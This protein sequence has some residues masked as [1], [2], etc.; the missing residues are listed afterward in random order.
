MQPSR[1]RCALLC[2]LVVPTLMSAQAVG[3]VGDDARVVPR[4]TLRVSILSE[5]TRYYER[6]GR[7]TPGRKDGALE[8][9][10]V[11]FTF[12][13]LGPLRLASL[14]P[15]EAGVRALSGMP[16]FN[17]SLGKIGVQ[18]RDR[19]VTTPLAIDVGLTQRLT[20]GVVIPFVT[21]TSEVDLRANPTGR[22]STLG[23]NPT[24]STPAAFSANA[25]LLAQFDSAAAQL[26]QRLSFCG[27]NPSVTGCGSLNANAASARDLIAKANGFATGLGQIYGGRNGSKGALFVPIS[28]TTAQAAIESRVAAYRALYATF[29]ATALTATGPFPAQVPLT[30]SDVQRVITDSAFGIRA[31][32]LAGSIAR[33]LGD[34]DVSVK[35]RVV[36]TFGK[37]VDERAAPKGFGWRQSVGAVYRLGTGTRSAPDNFTD[38]GTGDHQNDIEMR[39]FTDLSFGGRLW[40]AL[41]A[42]YNIQ[43]AD[44][45]VTRIPE[46]PDKPLAAAYRQQTVK[47]DLGDE[48]D[49][50]VSPRWTFNESVGLS[51]Y[52][53]YR[54]K[55]SD[56]Y[57][58]TFTVSNLLGQPER[59][60]AAVLG[61]ET[62][63]REHRFGGGVTYS[64][65]AAF[66]RGAAAFPVEVTYFHFQTTLG[67]G[68]SVPKLSMDQLQVRLYRRLFGR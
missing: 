42:R 26:N 31:Q 43:M 9:L 35:F 60:D 11:D 62:E 6:Y 34:V 15:I 4:G 50:S 58:G 13:T 1:L 3:G 47:R 8:P 32:P 41:V 38:L 16:D 68:G 45:R 67:S 52:Y 28:G 65:V 48:L 49:V 55:F 66:E 56:A 59:I 5:W 24:L 39:S 36:D 18:V 12:D 53:S 44:E 2:A 30:S 33:G 51:G 7:S 23:F 29:G 63:A 61:L 22:E 64:T 19:L 10:G 46:S 25:L 17:A 27:N 14:A 20:V 21:A 54:R 40:V 37:T 57:S